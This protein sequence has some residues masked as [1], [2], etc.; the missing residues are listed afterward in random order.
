VK[1]SVVFTVFVDTP[2]VVVNRHGRKYHGDIPVW[3]L[4][5]VTGKIEGVVNNR[6]RAYGLRNH[7][8]NY[9]QK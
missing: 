8:K 7:I 3:R 5:N 1:E 4:N 9:K 2:D 6:G